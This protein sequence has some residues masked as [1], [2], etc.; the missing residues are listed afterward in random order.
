M[1]RR[2]LPNGSPIREGV[3]LGGG[4]RFT[5]RREARSFPPRP[6]FHLDGFDS[7]TKSRTR[8]V[9]HGDLSVLRN[10]FVLLWVQCY[11]PSIDHSLGSR[12]LVL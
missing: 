4:G 1:E 2:Q 9:S 11:S 7:E 10:T 5:K 12:G 6:I 8:E 3:W